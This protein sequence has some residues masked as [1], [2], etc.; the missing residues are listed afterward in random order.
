MSTYSSI[1][2]GDEGAM[3]IADILRANKVIRKISG[4]TIV[5]ASILYLDT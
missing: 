1:P 5:K 2:I 3:L 4:P